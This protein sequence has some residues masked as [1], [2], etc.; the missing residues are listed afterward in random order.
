MVVE[1]RALALAERLLLNGQLG[2]GCRLRETVPETFGNCDEHVPLLR[3]ALVSVELLPDYAADSRKVL[4]ALDDLP[5]H[6]G[7]RGRVWISPDIDGTYSS[8]WEEEDD[9]L[10]Q[11]PEQ[12]SREAVTLWAELRS[13][14]VRFPEP[15]H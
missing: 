11:G 13:D 3:S 12:C 9:W 5:A 8:Y 6:I 2:L 1:D 15:E 14:D 4:N 10:E 7:R